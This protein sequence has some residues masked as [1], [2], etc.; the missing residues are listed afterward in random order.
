M[1]DTHCHF[2][3][4]PFSDDP[5]YW[6]QRSKDTGI[7]HLIVPA[8]ARENWGRVATLAAS[9]PEVF[10]A[11]GLHPVW[12]ASHHEDDIEKLDAFLSESPK[13][14]VAIG[15]CGLDFAIENA[16]P[17]RQTWFLTEQLKLAE[18]YQ[19]PVILHC[20][21]AHN[22]LLQILNRFSGVKGV[23]HAFSGS[24]QIG[25][26]YIRR[27]FLLGIGGTI[28]YERANKT[29]NAV[30]NFPL[31]ALVLETDAPDMPVFGYQGEPNLPERMLL[32][33]QTLAHLKHLPVEEIIHVTSQNSTR[34][35]VLDA[36]YAALD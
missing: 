22:E 32:I 20:R 14:C 13:G 34:Y 8:V 17:E 21:K 25:L 26:S 31:N 5:A 2:D 28:T 24:E 33:A 9:F 11:V 27:G 6:V 3:F 12:M 35:F 18:K 30:K 23:L 7:Q 16:D 1:I 4:P 29:R 15:E 36:D 10:Y 19:L